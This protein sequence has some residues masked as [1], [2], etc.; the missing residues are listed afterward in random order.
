M[1]K[2]LTIRLKN[3]PGILADLGELLGKHNINMEA[4]CGIPFNDESVLHIV[5][6]DETTTKYIL[7]QEGFNVSAI[8]DVILLDIADLAGKAGSGGKLARKIGNAGVN[9]DT[10]Y[11]AE[12]NRIVLGVDNIDKAL[13]ALGL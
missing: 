7:E 5:V 3:K 8:R 2:D 13:T 1:L 12:N 6:E 9:I 10:I 4:L 11:L